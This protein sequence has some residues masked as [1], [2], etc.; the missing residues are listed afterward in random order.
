MVSVYL[1]HVYL[2]PQPVTTLLTNPLFLYVTL[3]IPNSKPFQFHFVSSDG[4]LCAV[5]RRRD[6]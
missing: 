2:L 5:A 4:F 3:K 1:T 6:G